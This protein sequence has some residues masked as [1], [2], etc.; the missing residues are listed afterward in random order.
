MMKRWRESAKKGNMEKLKRD[1]YVEEK[2]EILIE[3]L[4]RELFMKV[5]RIVLT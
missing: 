4:M 2:R 1:S 3:S 5:L